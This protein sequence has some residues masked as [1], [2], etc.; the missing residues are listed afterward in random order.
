MNCLLNVIHVVV[1]F[2]SL[3]LNFLPLYI[4]LNI[5]SIVLSDISKYNDMVKMQYYKIVET[6]RI[7]PSCRELCLS[8]F[9]TI[10]HRKV[11]MVAMRSLDKK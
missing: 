7:C 11:L 5:T 8:N 6:P 10:F 1:V 3:F 9:G 2:V 4:F